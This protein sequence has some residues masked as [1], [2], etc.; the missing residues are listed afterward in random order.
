M[1]IEIEP[2]VYTARIVPRADLLAGVAFAY[3]YERQIDGRTEYL[4]ED[5]A[6]RIAARQ[7]SM[8]P[9]DALALQSGWA[10]VFI[11][12]NL[13]LFP[14]AD[15]GTVRT[16]DAFLFQTPEVRF[17]NPIVPRLTY[18]S[19]PLD[20]SDRRPRRTPDPVLQGALRRRGRQDQRGRLDAG[21]LQL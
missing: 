5:T 4:S 9:L 6:L 20:G 16:S 19:F 14:V 11:Q 7:V 18:E 21:P 17:A 2:E 8:A 1:L 10:S 12:R 3:L 13:V 15:L